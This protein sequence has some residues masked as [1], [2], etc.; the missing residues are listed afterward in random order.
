[1][2]EK[3]LCYDTLKN[4]FVLVEVNDEIASFMRRSHWR[5]DIQQ[6]RYYKRVV[7]IE[8]NLVIGGNSIDN[9]VINREIRQ[10]LSRIIQRLSKDDKTLF[11][12][13]FQNEL[14]YKEIAGILDI[15]TSYVAKKVNILKK[16]LVQEIR[17]NIRLNNL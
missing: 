3:I 13:R 9:I 12:L 8:D 5:E 17:K 2:M 7:S 6:R 14:T 10:E 16:F 1:M 15:S 11:N 4:S